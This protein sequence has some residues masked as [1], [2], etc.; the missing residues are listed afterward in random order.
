MDLTGFLSDLLA[1]AGHR[2]R[3][4]N[5]LKS[6]GLNMIEKTVLQQRIKN[7]TAG[8]AA[9]TDKQKRALGSGAKLKKYAT[10]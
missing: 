9:Y 5:V 10:K 3:L 8:Q 2:T 6:P 1:Y 4:Q 7:M